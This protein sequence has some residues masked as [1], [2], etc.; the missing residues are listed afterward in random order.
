MLVIGLLL[1]TLVAFA[2]ERATQSHKLVTQP[3]GYGVMASWQDISNV[4]VIGPKDNFSS[5]YNWLK[6]GTRNDAMGALSVENPRILILL[7]G[8][9]NDNLTVDTDYVY[10][11]ASMPGVVLNGTITKTATTAY[12]YLWD[13]GGSYPGSASFV[14]FTEL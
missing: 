9:Y 3:F 8:I 11:D 10:V 4:K 2:A 12:L 5:E 13:G 14:G 1:I 7:P 6:S